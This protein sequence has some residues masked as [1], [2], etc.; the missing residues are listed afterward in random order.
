MVVMVVMIIMIM[1]VVMLVLFHLPLFLEEIVNHLFDLHTLI[2]FEVFHRETRSKL[3]NV[4]ELIY[5]SAL[6]DEDLKLTI[7]KELPH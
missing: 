1:V 2:I 4:R 3:V 6:T 7:C 5:F